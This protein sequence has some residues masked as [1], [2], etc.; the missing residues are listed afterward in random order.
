MEKPEKQEKKIIRCA[1][2]TRVKT[3]EGLEQE[4]SSLDNQRESAESYIQSQ[5]SEGWTSLPERY[6]DGGYT[7]A[8]TD[9]PALQKLMAD[10]REGKIDSVVTYKV[11]RL[12]RSLLDF[13]QILEFFDQNNVTFVSVTQAFNTNTSMGRL[14]LN[15]LLSFA[16]FER[17]IISERT[18]DKMGAARKKGKWVGGM[19]PLGYDS[20]KVNHKLVINQQE[21][22]IVKKIFSLYLEKGSSLSVA[23]ALNENGY[24]TK[25]HLGSS[26]KKIGGMKFTSSGV[27]LFI[28]NVTYTGKVSY[29][30]QIYQGEHEPII[31][32]KI[33]QE[34][35]E[36]L[37]DNRPE[38][39][40][41]RASNNKGLL[42]NI[43]HCKDCNSTMY[44]V[45]SMKDKHKYHYYVCMNA[46]KRGYKN[47]PTRIIAAQLM[48]NKFM[49]FLRQISDDP[50]IGAKAWEALTL[51][52]KIPLI[53]SIAKAAHYDA[54]NETL[55]IMLH[56]ADISRQ[57]ALKLAELKHIPH[58]RRQAQVSKE[59]LVRQNL[60]LAHQ[61]SRVSA[62]KN[63]TLKQIAVW[64][65]ITH[66]RICH[67]ANMLLVSPL[68]QEEILL[69][70]DKALY[71]IPEYRLREVIKELDWDKQQEIW[72]DLL[73]L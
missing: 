51:E 49:E 20:D 28:K 31:S 30:G 46:Q 25:I 50:R 11:D 4:F 18:R 13:S 67:I 2:Y 42:N 41:P 7:G 43:L 34:A 38:R 64:I 15:I 3:S 61:I 10:I 47:C 27:Q 21:A 8:N 32:D 71:N 14:T 56:K 22:E 69:S 39:R 70:I 58:H 37:A 55:E 57:F 63:C 36:I 60:I 9:R 66:S 68:I 33:F 52:E 35:Q 53:K 48:E 12:S 45:Y 59:P 23:M 62:E 73:K 65:G 29:G 16:Q 1:I 24:R 26:G 5:K 6:D 19:V 72:K 44:Y 40:V 54:H 17:E